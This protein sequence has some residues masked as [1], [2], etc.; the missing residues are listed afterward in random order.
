VRLIDYQHLKECLYDLEETLAI[1]NYAV[2]LENYDTD[3]LEN[4]HKDNLIGFTKCDNLSIN[5][6]FTN[7]Y[8]KYS[9]LLITEIDKDSK[10]V[11]ISIVD[12]HEQ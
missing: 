10:R 1:D 9:H 11:L 7:P 8:D 5:D 6:R 3:T 4:T 2:F 12:N